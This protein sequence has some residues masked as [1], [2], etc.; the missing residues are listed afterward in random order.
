MARNECEESGVIPVN[1]VTLFK[2]KAMPNSYVFN[3]IINNIPSTF[4]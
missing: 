1:F 3:G 4:K 2:P